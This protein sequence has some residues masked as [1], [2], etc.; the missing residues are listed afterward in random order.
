[1]AHLAAKGAVLWQLSSSAPGPPCPSASPPIT[2]RIVLIMPSPSPG[3]CSHHGPLP[4]LL[5][6]LLL[7]LLWICWVSGFYVLLCKPPSRA[8]S[9]CPPHPIPSAG[10]LLAYLPAAS[11][12]GC[13]ASCGPDK[14]PSSNSQ[15][16]CIPLL[17]PHCPPLFPLSCG[18]EE[19][20]Q[21]PRQMPV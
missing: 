18:A 20:L 6:S 16:R 12:L 11:E 2:L 19:K 8:C 9:M 5:S 3:Q 14:A 7:G 4:T 21:K 13:S 10:L 1:M 17:A 15:S